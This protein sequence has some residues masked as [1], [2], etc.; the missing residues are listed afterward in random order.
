MPVR[1]NRLIGL[2][3]AVTFSANALAP[4]LL[5]GCGDDWRAE[6]RSSAHAPMAGMHHE[7]M[8]HR[9]KPGRPGHSH[10]C[11]CVGHSCCFTAA[12]LPC[13]VRLPAVAPVEVVTTQGVFIRRAPVTRPEHLLPLAQAPPLSV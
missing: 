7:G 11:Q 8:D 9:G 13:T 6:L 4:G 3:L 1:L 12:A 2:L 5:H 10:G